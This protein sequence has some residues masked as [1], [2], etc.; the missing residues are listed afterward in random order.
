MLEAVS[1]T[2]GGSLGS[3][4]IAGLVLGLVLAWSKPLLAGD[5]AL[6]ESLFRE[7]KQLMQAR[8]YARACPKLSE[9]YRQ[10]PASGTL[11]ALALCQEQAGQTASAWGSYTSAVSRARQEG[12]SDR[13]QAAR[14]R[15]AALE[16]KLSRLTV[17]VAPS[18]AQLPGFSLTRDGAPLPSAAWGSAMPV[19]PGEHVLEASADGKLPWR[20]SVRLGASADRQTAKVTALEDA[21]VTSAP[22][23]PA[24]APPLATAPVAA[25]APSAPSAPS[26]APSEGTNAKPTRSGGWSTL[27]WVGLTTGGI[28][29]AALGAA[30]VFAI[31]ARDWDHYSKQDGHCDKETGCDP[32][33][34]ALNRHAIE[35]ANIATVLSIGGGAVAALGL[36]L[37]I[38]GGFTST[39]DSASVGVSTQ[40]ASDGATLALSGAF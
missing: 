37:F 36:T 35:E 23:T 17:E 20:K 13:E 30:G 38:V 1:G 28:G 21:P 31:R 40:V 10:D 25:P 19:D 29:L 15:A 2:H 9:S 18:V 33:G 16:P 34:R 11:L 3:R 7:G 6:A 8:D 4:G 26:T 27:R 39:P 5:A 22:A 12:R 14:E 24:P 32:T